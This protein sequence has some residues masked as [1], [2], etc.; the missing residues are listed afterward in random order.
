MDRAFRFAGAARSVEYE[1]RIVRARLRKLWSLDVA[2]LL[3][4]TVQVMDREWWISQLDL[5]DGKMSARAD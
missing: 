3:Q 2:S 1:S 4:Q 5:G